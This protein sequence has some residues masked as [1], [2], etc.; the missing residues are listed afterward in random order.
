MKSSRNRFYSL[1]CVDVSI[2]TLHR[3]QAKVDD[4]YVFFFQSLAWDKGLWVGGRYYSGMW[5]WEG[6]LTSTISNQSSLWKPGQP[7]GSGIVLYIYLYPEETLL[8]D[9]GSNFIYSFVCEAVLM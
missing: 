4:I 8:Y 2:P 3:I 5:R 6:R 1:V 7:N 9:Q